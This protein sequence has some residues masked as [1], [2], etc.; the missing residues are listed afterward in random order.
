MMG[1]ADASPPPQI[2]EVKFD[3]GMDSRLRIEW[4][5]D[6]KGWA[7]YRL[8]PWAKLSTEPLTLY[9]QPMFAK[10][11]DEKGGPSP[12]QSTGADLLQ[13]YAKFNLPLGGSSR[14][15]VRL[16]RAV[17][18]LG[19]ERLV[20]A[21]WGTNVPRSF[22]GS[23]AELTVHET[24]LKI[25]AMRQV[26]SGLDSFDN[27]AT[28]N[29]KLG[30]A[31]LVTPIGKFDFTLDAYVLR[32]S[33]TKRRFGAR[34]DNRRTSIGLRLSGASGGWHWNWEAV[35][36]HGSADARER[37]S[38]WTLA[39]ETGREF[40][41]G[42]LHGIFDLKANIAS[43]G[44][45]DRTVRNFDPLFPKAKYFG[46]LT[47]IGPA[48]IVNLHPAV[49]LDLANHTK[50]GVSGIRYWRLSAKEPAYSLTGSPIPIVGPG[51]LVGDQAEVTLERQF[52]KF[53]ALVSLSRFEP[54]TGTERG[55]VL[56]ETTLAA[57]ELSLTI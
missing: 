24:D 16:G 27:R 38:A 5:T 2:E 25:F 50:L 36:Q 19:M 30:G 8:M 34:A 55:E 17:E 32:T 56:K 14:F 31:Y 22:D 11:I 3:I 28:S 33:F 20:G 39:T 54:S 52:G 1:P 10:S 21:R 15:S 42:R 45:S 47:P 51:K 57:F 43:G 35:A 44:R 48:N 37:L 49:T 7:N 23:E 40:T 9:V 4:N 6:D 46:E 12:N 29:G 18:R 41:I 13:A 26:Q 53:D